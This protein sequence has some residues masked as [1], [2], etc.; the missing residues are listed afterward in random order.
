MLLKSTDA[1][2]TWTK[3]IIYRCPIPMFDTNGMTSDTNADG[4]ADT[5]MSHGGDQ[6]VVIEMI[7]AIYFSLMYVG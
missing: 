1:G 4:V 6:A 5:V 2:L 3:T 7:L